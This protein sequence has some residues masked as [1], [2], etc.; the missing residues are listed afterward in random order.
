MQME[1]G[2]S[3]IVAAFIA[4]CGLTACQQASP[5]APSRVA[6][7]DAAEL[8][9]SGDGSG[10]VRTA[11]DQV[12]VCHLNDERVFV[13]LTVAAPALDGH[14]AHGDGLPGGAVP[15]TNQTFDS[16]CGVSSPPPPPQDSDADGVPNAA[17]NCPFASNPDQADGDGD[18]IGDV[19]E[20]PD[21]FEP[22]NTAA[23]AANLGT[24]NGANAININATFHDTTADRNDFYAVRLIEASAS[25]CFPASSQP[26]NLRITM[27]PPPTQDY[28][29]FVRLAGGTLLGQS[30]NGLGQTDVVNVVLNGSCGTDD[31]WDVVIEV[32]YFTGPTQPVPG[33]YVLGVTFGAAP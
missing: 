4:A 25:G 5:T 30:T 28:D 24:L 31:S 8:V 3:R 17:D 2:A 15:G 9:A 13:P 12:T 16:S 21:N 22:N 7:I 20:Q 14:L 33:I 29:L 1:S 18:G 23:S 19:C 27:T 26:H 11:Q 6:S 10:R 32:R